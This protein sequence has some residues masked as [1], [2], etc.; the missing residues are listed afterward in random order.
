MIVEF[1]GAHTFHHGN[2]VFYYILMFFFKSSLATVKFGSDLFVHL[3]V[4]QW[5][6]GRCF[7]HIL[8]LFQTERW[9]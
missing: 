9:Q 4:A 1:V 2:H 8:N 3:T 6:G 7:R 5:N